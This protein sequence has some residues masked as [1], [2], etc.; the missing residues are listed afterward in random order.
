MIDKLISS[1]LVALASEDRQRMPSIEVLWS[2]PPSRA[3]RAKRA[4]WLVPAAPILGAFIAAGVLIE[5]DLQT[6][7]A[8]P[9]LAIALVLSVMAML[10]LVGSR[11]VRSDRPLADVIAVSLF[12]ATAAA[13]F[14]MGWVQHTTTC[15]F[16]NHEGATSGPCLANQV[17]TTPEFVMIAWAISVVTGAIAARRIRRV[18]PREWSVAARVVLVTVLVTWMGLNQFWDRWTE[19]VHFH[20]DPASLAVQL[21]GQI[22]GA[23]YRVL[24]GYSY[25]ELEVSP[26]QWH[27]VWAGLL[28][29]AL[30]ISIGV[31]SIRDRARPSRWLARLES[32]AVIP[33]GVVVSTASLVFAA[34]RRDYGEAGVY[35]ALASVGAVVAYASMLLRRR[36]REALS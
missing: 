7:N 6:F 31:A 25:L 19:V 17:F 27:A 4:S 23:E 14:A 9:Q 30:A 34:M 2:P 29:L 1:D 35:A 32:A 13:A 21:G 26:S 11:P 15:L 5:V 36:R 20:H 12:T 28:L 3:P 33:L 22:R 24:Y 8:T 16:L 18:G 10:G